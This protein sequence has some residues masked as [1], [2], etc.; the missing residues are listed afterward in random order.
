FQEI[1]NFGS[2]SDLSEEESD[3]FFNI[4][5]NQNDPKIIK[6]AFAN[7]NIHNQTIE[8]CQLQ[9]Y[10]FIP[11]SEKHPISSN[12]TNIS[13]NNI[14]KDMIFGKFQKSQESMDK[15]NYYFDL[16]QTSVVLSDSDSLL[17]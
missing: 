11:P 13:F 15:L 10:Q 9:L 16:R 14:F 2:E 6:M 5:D 3:V 7:N 4:Q 17:W 12:P 8:E 1:S